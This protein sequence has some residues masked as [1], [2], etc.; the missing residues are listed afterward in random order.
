[1]MPAGPIPSAGC[2]FAEW[3]VPLCPLYAAAHEA[4]LPTCLDDLGPDGCAVD[5]G[6]ATY[7]DLIA[8]LG[9]TESGAA[10]IAR[11]RAALRSPTYAGPCRACNGTG[12]Q[13][14]ATG[15][16]RPCS[17]CRAGDFAAWSRARGHHPEDAP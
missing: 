4:G 16:L 9:E 5:Q 2:P 15:G 14:A 3:M 13:I 6:R 17:R 8:A 7:A 12:A 10:L 1:M 11:A